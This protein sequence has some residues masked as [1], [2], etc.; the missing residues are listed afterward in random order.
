MAEMEAVISK[1]EEYARLIVDNRQA[2]EAFR[3]EARAQLRSR[4]Q[5]TQKVVAQIIQQTKDASRAN[6]SELNTYFKAHDEERSG[7]RQ[8]LEAAAS[9][10]SIALT[11]LR[12]ILESNES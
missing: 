5:Q 4:T 6:Q 2:L 11:E 10:R 12:T 8:R 9:R 3:V 7:S 1:L